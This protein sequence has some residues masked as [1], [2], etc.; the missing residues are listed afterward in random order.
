MQACVLP[1][2]LCCLSD[3]C[4][5]CR[6]CCPLFVWFL[7]GAWSSHI[8]FPLSVFASTHVLY[9]F[10]TLCVC[11]HSR[12]C[13]LCICVNSACVTSTSLCLSSVSLPTLLVRTLCVY[14]N[15]LC[16]CPL[17]LSAPSVT[18][19]PLYV[20]VPTMCLCPPSCC[21]SAHSGVHSVWQ[22][23]LC[24]SYVSVSAAHS[25]ISNSLCCCPL[26]D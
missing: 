7:F 21:L 3:F 22:C 9:Y 2:W 4:C 6:S 1:V 5:C 12:L 18:F 13:P 14:V 15:S 25:L 17:S 23:C 11:I 26:S 24:H 16:L 10:P 20:F 8:I 19:C